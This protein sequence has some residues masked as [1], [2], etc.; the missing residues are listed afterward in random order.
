MYVCVSISSLKILLCSLASRVFAIFLLVLMFI[1]ARP[2][3]TFKDLPSLTC[4]TPLNLSIAQLAQE[5]LLCLFPPQTS[6]LFRTAGWHLLWLLLLLFFYLPL[7]NLQLFSISSAIREATRGMGA[8]DFDYLRCRGNFGFYFPVANIVALYH[9]L[10]GS[11]ET[12]K[13]NEENCW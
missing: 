4:V 8:L 10:E 11:S 5:P 9:S 1:W 12:R 3:D 7:Q 6:C 13:N 2:F